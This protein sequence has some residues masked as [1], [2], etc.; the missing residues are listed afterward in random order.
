[1][2]FLDFIPKSIFE[3]IGVFAGIGVSLIIL[4]QIIKEYRS[5]QPSTLTLGFLFGWL[6]IYTFWCLYGI[7]MGTIA[8]W[9]SNAL[10]IALQL[11]LCIIVIRKKA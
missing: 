10:A 6:I 2:D 5:Q 8:I 4:S 1:M 9:M 7:R 3:G 11:L